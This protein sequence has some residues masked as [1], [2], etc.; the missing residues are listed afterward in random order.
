MLFIKRKLNETVMI[1]DAIQ[2]KIIANDGEI[3]T[4]AFQAPREIPIHRREMYKHLK[5]LKSSI[6]CEINC[7]V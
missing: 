1:G 5:K 2:V 7:N 3:V 6:V 4:L